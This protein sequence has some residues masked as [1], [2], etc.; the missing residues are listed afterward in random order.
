[1][2]NQENIII[3]NKKIENKDELFKIIAKKAFDLKITTNQELVLKA[4]QDRE[5]QGT[6]GFQDGFGIPHG[7]TSTILK[8]TVLFIRSNVPIK[9]DSL[10]GKPLQNLFVLLIPDEQGDEHLKILALIARHLMKKE[11]RT[12]I[13]Q[14]NTKTELLDII[15]EITN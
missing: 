9:W 11:F 8:P 4:I 1:M 5:A 6:T 7:R 3:L 15:K 2:F 13:Q 14:A 12:R 10:D